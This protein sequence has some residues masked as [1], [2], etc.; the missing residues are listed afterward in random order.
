MWF[1][2]DP[3]E[4]TSLFTERDKLRSLERVTYTADRRP[5]FVKC[6]S[7][8]SSL[9]SVWRVDLYLKGYLI[10]TVT[11]W[12]VFL[13]TVIHF[14]LNY[15]IASIA[16]SWPVIVEPFQKSECILVITHWFLHLTF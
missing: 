14:A 16:A 13:C 12:H 15:S 10:A 6:T 5:L 4:S 3:T 8:H 7:R 2:S 9:S 1:S 11:D